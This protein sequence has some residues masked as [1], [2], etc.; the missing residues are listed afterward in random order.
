M[1]YPRRALRL[2]Y[3]LV[4]DR[5]D[6]KMDVFLHDLKVRLLRLLGVTKRREASPS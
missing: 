2:L 4:M 5:E 3:N 1:T 6:S